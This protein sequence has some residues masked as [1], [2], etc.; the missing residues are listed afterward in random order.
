MKDEW[1]VVR[2]MTCN[3]K[4]MHWNGCHKIYLSM[5]DETVES[6]REYEY[7]VV[8]PDPDLLVKWFMESCSLRFV[9]AVF[10]GGQKNDDFVTLIP[11]GWGEAEY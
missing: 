6:F 8:D 9:S 4:A 10:H 5:D 2:E 7:E 3:S 1:D 11:Q